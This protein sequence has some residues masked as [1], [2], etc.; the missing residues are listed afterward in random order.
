MNLLDV[1]HLVALTAIAIH[2]GYVAQRLAV[3]DLRKSPQFT[4]CLLA[5]LLSSLSVGVVNRDLVWEDFAF[6]PYALAAPIAIGYLLGRTQTAR[7]TRRASEQ[8]TGSTEQTASWRIDDTG[9]S[10]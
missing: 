10:R 4:V 5:I 8:T 6:F 9:A 1:F 3:G 2:F 7:Q